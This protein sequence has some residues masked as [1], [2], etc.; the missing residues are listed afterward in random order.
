MCPPETLAKTPEGTS[1][2]GRSDS[3]IPSFSQNIHPSELK[4]QVWPLPSGAVQALAA[5]ITTLEGPSPFW[6]KC[7]LCCPLTASYASFRTPP[8]A[9]FCLCLLRLPSPARP[10]GASPP[11]VP[12][13]SSA[14]PLLVTA[15]PLLARRH[16]PPLASPSAAQMQLFYSNLLV[17]T[18]ETSSLSLD[19]E[20]PAS[21]PTVISRCPLILPRPAAF[22]L[23]VWVSLS[24][25][26]VPTSRLLYRLPPP[27]ASTLFPS[28][29]A[30]YS[31]C[32]SR[33]RYG[34]SRCDFSGHPF[35]RVT[36]ILLFSLT[37]PCESPSQ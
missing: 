4:A 16:E 8:S 10:G 18:G 12:P 5:Q 31:S 17:E 27:G 13:V 20:K 30:P 32:R 29:P 35:W 3:Q 24:T 21:F 2:L 1:I 28:S 23:V 22:C 14:A 25:A 19:L 6:A 34:S 33:L 37:P 26:H 11:P 36:P 9:P 15:G 7:H